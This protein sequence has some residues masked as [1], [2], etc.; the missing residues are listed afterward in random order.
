MIVYKYYSPYALSEERFPTLQNRQFYFSSVEQLND[1]F[2]LYGD[3]CI[4][5]Q[6][7]LVRHWLNVIYDVISKTNSVDKE[8]IKNRYATSVFLTLLRTSFQYASCSFSRVP[9]ERLMWAHY[10]DS[11]R[12]FCLE[13]AFPD[14]TTELQKVL[15]VDR[16]PYA[17][18][19]RSKIE[20]D[21]D[22]D[23]NRNIARYLES[24]YFLK[25][26]SLFFIEDLPY[27][28]KILHS[29]T[30]SKSEYIGAVMDLWTSTT[31]AKCKEKEQFMN[32]LYSTPPITETFV[33]EK[34]I[35]SLLCLK[36]QEW[37]YEQE[38]RLIT[39]L[40][41]E[42]TGISKDWGQNVALRKI[43]LGCRFDTKPANDM[44][45][46]IKQLQQQHH[47]ELYRVNATNIENFELSIKK[48]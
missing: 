14:D 6:Y 27:M 10:A 30:N 33:N 12:G 17:T 24:G 47:A 44:M 15:Y 2:D 38:E 42:Q 34:L 9:L 28:G 20:T 45:K 26:D 40:S 8:D 5:G 36:S 41:L 3:R 19:A 18:S 7:Q 39:K 1:P 29:K 16:L 37:C 13:F 46:R 32:W 43:I 4:I 22:A 48:A 31:Q 21:I 11:H 23:L 25:Q 35:R